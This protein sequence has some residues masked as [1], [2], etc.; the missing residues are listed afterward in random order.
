MDIIHV[1]TNDSP[2]LLVSKPAGIPSAP[3]FEGDDSVLTQAVE[4]YPQI[5][6]V[7]GKKQVEHGLVHR[8]DTETSGLVL[9]ATSQQSYDS[10]IQSQKEGKFQKWYRAEIERIPDCASRLG[11][12]PPLPEEI[13]SYSSSCDGDTFMIQSAFR[14]F[15]Q[16]GREVRPVTNDAGRA[17]QKKG[18]S[19]LYS[20]EI[21]LEDRNT[22]ICRIKAGFRHQV[23]CHLAWCG[24]PVKGDRIYNPNEKESDVKSG[25]MKFFA[26]KISFPH[27]LTGLPLVFQ[28]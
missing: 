19:V 8:I 16:K 28:M 7:H 20:T 17:A 6:S 5:A 18:G 21:C 3:L 12:F 4:M 9:I 15:A 25:I 27:P 22:A 14:A 24:F 2:F 26:C 13:R 11:G 1:P 23:R 10:L